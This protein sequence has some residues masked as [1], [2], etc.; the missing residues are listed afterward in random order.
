MG[1]TH[2]LGQPV[3]RR[4]VV[5]AAAA[6]ALACA[7]MLIVAG[8]SLIKARE[9]SLATD[10]L[11][12]AVDDALLAAIEAPPDAATPETVAPE[13]MAPGEEAPGAPP[14]LEPVA[15]RGA[16]SEPGQGPA[17]GPSG[18]WA[19]TRLAQP[20]A[21]ASGM[22]EA[23]GYRIA[24]AGIE[25]V[26]ADRMCSH[27]GRDWP[28]GARARAA[29]RAFLRGRAITCVVPPENGP[30]IVTADCLVGKQDVAAWLVSN[31]WA[32]ALA[33]GAYA[34]LGEAAQA[35]NRGIFG[36]PPATATPPSIV[37]DSEL[38]PPPGS[39][40]ATNGG[41]ILVMPQA[42][43]APL[44]AVPPPAVP[45]DPDAVFPPPPAPPPEPAQ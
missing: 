40:D 27:G 16:L 12:A 23:K 2:R 22:I 30:E 25:P 29:F 39:D 31:G 10:D 8:G 13:T 17:P 34:E 9:P 35:A 19:P 36:P 4:S 32:P 15:P 21:M 14:P 7:C 1:G 26:P 18:E 3:M 20:V 11:T 28:C 44:G 6:G 43:G 5:M 33:G 42:A 24:L 37:T 41:S 45:I 38:P